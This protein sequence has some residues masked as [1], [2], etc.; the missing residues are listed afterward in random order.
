MHDQADYAVCCEWGEPGMLH[1]ASTCDVTIIVD[2]LSFSTCVD[3]AVGRG[4]VVYPYRGSVE[5][6]VEF[7]ASVGA[8]LAYGDH[9]PSGYTLSPQSLTGVPRRARLVLPSP[10]GSALTLLAGAMPTLTGCL[11]NSRAVAHAAQQLGRRIAVIPAGE[12][13]RSDGT[14]RPCWEDWVGAGAIIDELEGSRSPEAR[15]AAAA[16]DSAQ[17]DLHSALSECGSGLE[18]IQRGRARDVEL[19]AQFNASACAPLFRGGAYIQSSQ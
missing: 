1:V 12:R 4:A 16:F 9:S 13:W 7:A 2:V 11:R 5:S 15:A 6:A 10:N 19:A 18:L 3:I 17:A 8:E 14:L